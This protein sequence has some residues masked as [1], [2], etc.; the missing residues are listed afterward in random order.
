MLKVSISFIDQFVLVTRRQGDVFSVCSLKPLTTLHCIQHHRFKINQKIKERVM[1]KKQATNSVGLDVQ[2]ANKV[3][4]SAQ[5]IWDAGL[6]AF[7]KAQVEGNKVFEAL[8]SEGEMLKAKTRKN[9]AGLRVSEMAS[10]A[11]GTWDKLE[12]VFEDRVAR[13]ITKLGVP[14]RREI[15]E[16]TKRLNRLTDA[17]ERTAVPKTAKKSPATAKP[18]KPIKATK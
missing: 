4:E 2:L 3:R 17:L 11:T 1:A 9:V 16:L 10:K 18:A 5:Q 13:A 12:Q 8:V 14:S 7:A 15:D 6:G